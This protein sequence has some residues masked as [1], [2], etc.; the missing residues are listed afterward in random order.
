M[1]PQFKIAGLGETLWDLFPDRKR[2]GGAPTNFAC[3]C[4]Q[5]GAAASLISCLGEDELGREA[6]TELAALGLDLAA[7]AE[8]PQAPTGTVGVAL[9]EG[10][11]PSYQ[12]AEAVAWDEIPF[13]PAAEALASELAAVCFGSLSQRHPVSRQ[14]TGKVLAAMPEEA[15]KILDVNLRAPHYS[16]EIITPLLEQ[17]NV[18][19]L[20]DEE[21]PVLADYYGLS[22]DLGGQLQALRERFA[23]QLV[24]YTR[25]AEG[26]ILQTAEEEDH[27]AA[28]PTT[29]VDSVGAGDSFTAALCMSLLHGRSL[30]ECNQFANQVAAY[31]CSQQGACPAL[32]ARLRPFS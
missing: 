11:K 27:A 14:T 30:A 13:S 29:P 32:P 9:D 26:S 15:L 3:H 7:L 17:A 28:V 4:Q 22:G 5:L 12:I 2:L 19:K 18:L 16:Q 20:S 23:L 6:R 1:K 10:G 31:V 21:L 8:H 24:A 25:G